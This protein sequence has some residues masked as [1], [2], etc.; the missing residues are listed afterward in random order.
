M[1]SISD[2]YLHKSHRMAT[3]DSSLVFVNLQVFT[4][5]S[6]CQNVFLCG[7][8]DVNKTVRYPSPNL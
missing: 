1:L 5:C 8:L 4:Y 6:I 3:I 2:E 7:S